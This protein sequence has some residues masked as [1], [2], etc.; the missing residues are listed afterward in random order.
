MRP[1]PRRRRRAGRLPHRRPRSPTAIDRCASKSSRPIS[2]RRRPRSARLGGTDSRRLG[3]DVTH[4]PRE[5]SIQQGK[6]VAEFR[7]SERSERGQSGPAVPQSSQRPLAFFAPPVVLRAHETVPDTRVH[8]PHRGI[9]RHP[10]EESRARVVGQRGARAR[11]GDHRLVHGAAAHAHEVVLRAMGHADHLV[12][13]EPN[14][15][16]PREG[17]GGSHG[18]RR[19]RREPAARRHVARHRDAC[20]AWRRSE[21]V[22]FTQRR[23]ADSRTSVHGGPRR[24][25]G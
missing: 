19:R 17:V 4:S 22:E 3:D 23:P 10:I 16:E 25:R 1:P 2:P 15:G 18:E 21:P 24:A 14:P 5:R 13:R 12:E 11:P 8:Q 6:R 9:E 20:T 7:R